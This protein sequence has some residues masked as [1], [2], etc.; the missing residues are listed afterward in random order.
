M[1]HY[2]LKL[3]NSIF[4]SIFNNSYRKYNI[5][6]KNNIIYSEIQWELLVI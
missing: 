3:N 6:F 1:I 2:N 5:I 4:K